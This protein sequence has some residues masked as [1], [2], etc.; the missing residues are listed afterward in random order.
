[1]TIDNVLAILLLPYLGSSSDRTRTRLGRRRP[2]LPFLVGG[3][4]MLAGCLLV[5]L[6][7]REPPL[8]REEGERFS[9]AGS[10]RTP[11][12]P[13]SPAKPSTIWG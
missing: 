2:S 4:V 9:L 6:L 5:V 13:S 7:I 11:S 1:M 8:A 10:R 3:L 12:R